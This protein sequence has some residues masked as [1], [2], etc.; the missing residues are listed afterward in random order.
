MIRT[1]YMLQQLRPFAVVGLSA[2]VS[3]GVASQTWV[4]G[5][6]GAI[7]EAWSEA[8]V[9][10]YDL[11]RLDLLDTVL[12]HVEE[13][14]V[15]PG[16]IDWERMFVA[17]LRAV[18]RRAPSI[19]FGREEGSRLL[20][21]EVG[22]HRSVFEVPPIASRAELVEALRLAVG[23]VALWL[24][25]AEVR[26]E[27]GGDDPRAE[28]EY[29]LINGLL[30]TL[31]PHSVLLRPTDAE[32]MDDDNRGAY[33]GIGVTV[34]DRSGRLVL[35]SVNDDEPAMRAGLRRDD[36][37]ER[38]DGASALNI[39]ID[40]AMQ[41][42]RGPVGTDVTL[43][44]RRPNVETLLH[45]TLRRETIESAP[46]KGAVLDGGIGWV[47]I[48]SFHLNVDRDL[49]GILANLERQVPGGLRGLVIDLRGN[50]GGFVNQAVAVSDL[51]LKSGDIVSTVDGNGRKRDVDTAHN[52]GDEPTWPIAVL[53][54]ASSASASEIVA[55]ALQNNERAV[56][57]GE[58]SFGKGSVQTLESFPDGSKLKLTISKYLTPG[59]RSI[60]SVGIP[61]DIELI[62]TWFRAAATEGLPQ[63]AQAD[64]FFRERASREIDLE[65]HLEQTWVRPR[66]PVWSIRY[67]PLPSKEKP[68]ISTEFRDPGSHDF[69]VDFARDLL[70]AA[71]SSR[72]A[73]ILSVAGAVVDAVSDVQAAAISSGMGGL[74]VDWRDG[75]PVPRRGDQVP[76][77]I[78]VAVSNRDGLV[79]GTQPAI[80]VSVTNEGDRPLHRASAILLDHAV[81]EGLEFVFGLI[82]PGETRTWTRE[83]DVPVGVVDEDP[84]LLVSLRDGGDAPIADIPARLPV[85]APAPSRYRWRWDLSDA[86]TGNGN[87]VA[88]PGER[89]SLQVVVE[90]VGLGA[91]GSPEIRLK[92]AAG[93]AIDLADAN[94]TVG[95]C[96]GE[97]CVPTLAGGDRFVGVMEM[98]VQANAAPGSALSFDLLLEDAAAWDAVALDELS[99]WQPVWKT[100]VSFRVGDALP[101][102]VVRE[103]PEITLSRTAPL[104]E[105]PGR[106]T[107]SG[108]V[109]DAG[110]IAHVL[111]FVGG[112]KVFH[113]GSG[114][115]GAVSSVPFTAD[116]DLLEG[117]NPVTVVAIDKEG[118]VSARSAVT[119]VEVGPLARAAP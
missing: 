47:R 34:L 9:E 118:L 70:L 73:E 1:T 85:S 103:P 86:Q 17:S 36:L 105:G 41:R 87:G 33:G 23:P 15:E 67:V 74:G 11:I 76:V 98:R 99:E 32:F 78:T 112:D 30:S 7:P 45:V 6:E 42:L 64:L 31:D 61:A 57:V 90:N 22:G 92:T 27:R 5:A 29:S 108:V 66:E 19:L 109:E 107:I 14:Y 12:Y 16:R 95:T 69:P 91:G 83:V 24:D 8:S 96:E 117:R 48:E 44:V 94:L 106:G 25:P 10:P 97:K 82:P 77:S 72:R 119:W 56:V 4:D 39:G 89:L 84:P 26:V 68:Y 28:V 100:A 116:I 46:V 49:R 40:D 35:S 62:P 114:A 104:R 115:Q 58:H 20:H 102:G 53:M 59:D 111:M 21:V 52:T 79:G 18:E 13:T 93:S 43:D 51:F 3:L 113:Q 55:G 110:G 80:T 38:I 65:Q 54:S 2:G 81:V 75:A 37:I 60:Q 101:I 88:D 71:P 50:P 63:S